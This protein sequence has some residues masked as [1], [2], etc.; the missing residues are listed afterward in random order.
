[1]ANSTKKTAARRGALLEALSG[2]LSITAACKRAGISRQAYYLW[3]RTDATWQAETD[4]AIEAGTD[5]LEDEALRRA[6][7]HSDRL[8][9]LLLRARR[10]EYR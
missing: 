1:M 4:A 2:G 8:L 5:L 10:P 3:R 9:M 6:L 7:D